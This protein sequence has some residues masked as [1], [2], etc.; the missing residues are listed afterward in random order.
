MFFASKVEMDLE[1][2]GEVLFLLA[3]GAPRVKPARDSHLYLS[4]AK[5][6][7]GGAVAVLERIEGCGTDVVV[8]ALLAWC[9]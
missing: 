1:L 3:P 7:S 2:S 8:H 9:S 6:P 4:F 5:T